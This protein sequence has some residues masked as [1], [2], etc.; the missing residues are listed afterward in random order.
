[1]CHVG[2]EMLHE[3][4]A[5]RN[6]GLHEGGDMLH[7]GDAER[8]KVLAA[9]KCEE[10]LHAGDVE[11]EKATSADLGNEG[12]RGAPGLEAGIITCVADGVPGVIPK[13]FS[14]ASELKKNLMNNAE[15]RKHLREL[16]VEMLC[17][18]SYE[19]FQLRA[20]MFQPHDVDF[21]MIQEL[22]S[23]AF[24]L[25]GPELFHRLCPKVTGALVG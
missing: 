11:L 12:V 19:D 5:E 10:V 14:F 8:N 24:P 22:E 16:P 23:R 17:T 3:D 21:G 20:A 15:V 4:D 9:A 7:E 13:N 18:L 25:L 1:M 2:D 6:E